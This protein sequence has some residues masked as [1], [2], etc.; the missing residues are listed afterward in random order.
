MAP[1]GRSGFSLV[2]LMVALGFMGL[3]MG[4]MARVYLASLDSWGRVNE[5]LTAQRALRWALERIGEDLRMMGYLFPPPELRNLDVAASADPALQSAFMLVPGLSG[6]RS[7]DELSFIMDSPLPVRAELAGPIPGPAPEGPGV[8]G[9]CAGPAAGDG[10]GRGSQVRA[11]D[12]A[13]AEVP[14]PAQAQVPA[15][16]TVRPARDLRLRAGDLLLVAGARFEFAQVARPAALRSGRAGTVAVV[17]AG[18]AGGAPFAFRHEAGAL[19]QAVRPLRLVSYS[20]APMPLEAGRRDPGPGGRVPCLVRS[21]TAYPADR[22]VPRRS[23]PQ[24]REVVAENVRRFRVDF[25][26]DGAFPGIRGADYGATVAN[27][28][29]RVKALC[30]RD[31]AATRVSDPFWFRRVGGLVSVRLEIQGPVRRG[32]RTPV[33]GATLV[34]A[35]RNFGL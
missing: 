25:T 15:T 22:A 4:G 21:E 5:T 9:T 26:V 27:L 18:G 8:G 32:D 3:L 12:Q 10:S 1:K 24:G 35:P 2:E 34:V 28:N 11:P 13:Q 19:V 17:R 23:R 31:Q 29:A 30:G 6:G 20:V 16:V 7:E 14:V 33:R